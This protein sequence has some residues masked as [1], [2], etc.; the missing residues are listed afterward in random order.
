M[1]IYVE[2]LLLTGNNTN[3]ME[4]LLT[5]LSYEFSLKDLGELHYFLE[6]EILQVSYC[7]QSMQ[8]RYTQ[9]GQNDGSIST[10]HSNSGFNHFSQWRRFHSYTMF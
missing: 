10:H 8:K 3:H 9:Q 2:D 1:I 6:V 4:T 5:Y 7:K